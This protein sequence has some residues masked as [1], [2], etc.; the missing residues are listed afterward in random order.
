MTTD[1]VTVAPT[2]SSRHRTQVVG[3]R[4]CASAAA[5][6]NTLAAV[7][8]ALAA[9]ADGV[10][11]DV[12][13]TADHVP[14]CVHDPDL[15][16][17]AGSPLVVER[18]T[19]RQLRHGRLPGGHLVPTLGEVARVVAGRGLLVVDVKEDARVTATAKKVLAEVDGVA[20]D[21]LVITSRDPQLLMEVQRR[22]GDV[23][24]GLVADGDLHQSVAWAVGLGCTALHVEVGA[25][26]QHSHVLPEAH[27]A[28]LVLRAWTVNRPVDA[29]LLDRVGVPGLLTDVPGEILARL[30]AR[31]A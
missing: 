26:L 5:P 9:G 10:E 22:D 14:V 17:V 21:A 6:E 27:D 3:H 19:F 28:G 29:A 18:A 23:G 15:R 16:R 7:G 30:A 8:L 11:V 13:L 25:L 12:R 4:G 20:R 31:S 1:V 2:A 24:L